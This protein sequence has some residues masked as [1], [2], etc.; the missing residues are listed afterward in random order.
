MDSISA[1]R[2]SGQLGE[3]PVGRLPLYGA[4]SSR[5]RMLIADGRLPV[6]ARLP[7]ERELAAAMGLSRVTV[8]SAYARLR[9]DGWAS[10]RR[11]AGTF[12]ALPAGTQPAAWVPAP[13]DEAVI[14][15]AHAA[16]SAPP[17]VAAA[18]AAAL[19]D[20]PRL[21]PSH[22]YAPA[23]LPE[24]RARI[25]DR[26]TSR[27]LATTPEQILVTSGALHG[28]S[29][30]FRALLRRGDRLLFEQPTYPNALDAARSLGARPVAVALDSDDPELWLSGVEAALLQT[31]LAAA[32]VMPD[33]QNPTGLLL[34]DPGRERLARA[35]QTAATTAVVDET[36][37]EL[38][39]D[40]APPAPLAAYGPGHISVG[41]LSKAFW[42]GLRIGW[43]RADP[44]T[45]Q[46]LTAIA[47]GATM[48]GPAVEQLAACHLLDGADAALTSHRERLRAQRAALIEA[49]REL[50]PTWQVAVPA[51]GLVLW[52]KLPSR[53]STALTAAAPAHG[54]R[55]AAGPRFS[56][57]HAHDD[58]LRLPYTHPPDIL[59]RAVERLAAAAAE[60]SDD[61]HHERGRVLDVV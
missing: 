17:E 54:L 34:D 61:G 15:L 9:E 12:S 10:A 25:A 36:H 38:G 51:G 4:L 2:L 60:A 57:G 21:L 39:L 27:G 55:L 23:G 40:A 26:Y 7:A 41:S 33:Y 28:I 47:V 24:L 6:G 52:C 42:G 31:R 14:D 29:V 48:S 58:R 59:R 46:R 45:A 49:L 8:N 30:V 13:P 3:L 19:A 35:F 53:C 44:A 18:Y 5:L 56:P 1:H 16:P 37:V 43:V 32:Y 20:L 50:L 22:G 11:G